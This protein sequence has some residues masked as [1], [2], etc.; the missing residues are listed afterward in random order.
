MISRERP[1]ALLVDLDG[2]LRSFDP[3]LPADIERRYQLLDGELMR[4]AFTLSRILPVLVGAEAHAAWLDSVVADLAPV[5]GGHAQARAAVEE[6]QGHR[7]AVV[8]EALS[9]VR[10][11]RAARIPVGL[12]TNA[13]DWLDADL[14]KLGLTGDFDTVINSSVIGAH[15]PTR[16]FYDAACRAVGQAPARCLLVDDDDRNVR[17]ARVAGLSA[18]RWNGAADLP[19]LRA[20]LGL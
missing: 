5:A 2:V 3:S 1:L 15:K 18:Y 6:W 8:P 11:A 19:Y 20:A 10:E 17:G 13:T 4:S 16:E 12:A 7:G 9:L 14:A